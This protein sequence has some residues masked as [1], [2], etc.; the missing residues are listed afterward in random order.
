MPAQIDRLS[1]SG[2]LASLSFIGIYFYPDE[3]RINVYLRC[4][5]HS[6]QIELEEKIDRL[7][8]ERATTTPEQN[9]ELVAMMVEAQI[10][11]KKKTFIVGSTI[12]RQTKNDVLTYTTLHGA[13][14]Y[15]VMESTPIMAKYSYLLVQF[16]NKLHKVTD[17]YKDWDTFSEAIRSLIDGKDYREIESLD[18]QEAAGTYV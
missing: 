5:I 16:F 6:K 10:E 3:Q 2:N 18:D 14:K 12:N 1:A 4:K 15:V 13:T 8:R 11:S 9:A 7:I 17:P